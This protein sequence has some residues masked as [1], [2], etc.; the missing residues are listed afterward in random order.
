[1]NC[2]SNT[3]S[4][5]RLPVRSLGGGVEIVTKEMA[6]FWTEHP[7]PCGHVPFSP[8]VVSVLVSGWIERHF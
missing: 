1:M 2:I 3:E 8:S 7:T 4:A 5:E 6:G